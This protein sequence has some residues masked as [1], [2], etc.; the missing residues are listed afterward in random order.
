MINYAPLPEKL[1][2]GMKIYQ[3]AYAPHETLEVLRVD[4]DFVWLMTPDG[5]RKFHEPLT[6]YQLRQYD[7]ELKNETTKQEKKP[8]AQNAPQTRPTET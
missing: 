7:Y 8:C 4:G 1:D 6:T 5:S 2:V 3:R